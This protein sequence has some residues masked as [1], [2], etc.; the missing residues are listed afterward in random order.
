MSD[1]LGPRSINVRAR[2]RSFPGRR[3]CGSL[4]AEGGGCA[5]SSTMQDLTFLKIDKLI[6]HELPKHQAKDGVLSDAVT[7]LT[8]PVRHFFEERIR[9][10]LRDA[11]LPSD[12]VS[13]HS[14]PVPAQVEQLLA[15]Q[16]PSE[17]AVV[18]SS[19]TIASH[20]FKIQTGVHSEGLIGLA[21]CSLQTA[22]GLAIIKLEHEEGVRAKL[23]GPKGSQHFEIEILDDLM[24][25]K[26]TR[27]FKVALFAA[28]PG[29]SVKGLVCD[30]QRQR[31]QL[32]ATYFLDNGECQDRCRLDVMQPPVLLRG[33]AGSSRRSARPSAA[34]CSSPTPLRSGA[35]STP[36]LWWRARAD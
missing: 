22:R 18:D 17:K 20:L 1:R 35:N 27:V 16:K 26:H 25:T 2:G 33:A 5:R 9:A 15:Q 24:L 10:S 34:P 12:F 13:G 32:V 28:E 11:G 19:R 6:I 29:G 3:N 8:P 31:A 7:P 21:A 14:S 30:S 23:K 36:E 4:T